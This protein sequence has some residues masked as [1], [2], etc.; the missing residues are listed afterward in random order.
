MSI[1]NKLSCLIWLLWY[2]FACRYGSASHYIRSGKSSG[3]L[4]VRLALRAFFW[5]DSNIC[6][7]SW[8]IC[9]RWSSTQPVFFFVF[10]SPSGRSIG[11]MNTFYRSWYFDLHVGGLTLAARLFSTAFFFF[12]VFGWAWHFLAVVFFSLTHTTGSRKNKVCLLSMFMVTS[13]RGTT[14]VEREERKKVRALLLYCC[15]RKY[16]MCVQHSLICWGSS[17]LQPV[18]FVV[19]E[20][21]I[22]AN[23]C[24]FF[25]CFFLFHP[26]HTSH[27]SEFIF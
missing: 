7:F 18:S 11:P 15:L 20:G 23:L 2:N 19:N 13:R 16:L 4:L 27:Y 8:A 21:F 10:F 3:E 12:S 1:Q 9:C 25:L 26:L 17:V 5:C 14:R 24:F 6:V 22:Y